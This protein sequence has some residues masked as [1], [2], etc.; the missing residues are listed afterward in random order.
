M[1]LKN[2]V[3]VTKTAQIGFPGL[4][5][6]QVSVAAIS[7][8][9][10]RKLRDQS[11]ITKIDPKH[12]VPVKELDED[13]FIEKFSDASIKGWSG[14]KYKYLEELMLVDLSSVEDLEAEVEYS[15]ENAVM[16]L[17]NSQV[18][19]AW[20]NEQVFSLQAFRN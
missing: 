15:K 9:M 20:L 10:S 18:F 4:E 12:R 19:D 17:K 14:L 3:V 11:E 8:E 16:L 7:R 2:L 6:F 1:S 5:G 13:L